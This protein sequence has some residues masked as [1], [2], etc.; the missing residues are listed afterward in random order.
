MYT[1]QEKFC[2]T[3]L[4]MVAYFFPPLTCKLFFLRL[5]Q[6][7]KHK[8]MKIELTTFCISARNKYTSDREGVQRS[9]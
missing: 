3:S 2:T 8:K 5:C 9:A 1:L 7:A 4:S 6:Y